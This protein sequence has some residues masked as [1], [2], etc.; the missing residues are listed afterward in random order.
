MRTQC[1]YHPTVPAHFG[2]HKCGAAFCPGCISRREHDYYGKKK[3]SFFCPKC[4]IE[5]D[6]LGMGNIIPPF[7]KRLPAFFL[8]PFRP[9]PIIFILVVAGLSLFFANS[10]FVGIILSVIMLK[11]SYA[12]LLHTAQGKLSPPPMTVS[13]LTDELEVVF[14]QIGIIIVVFFAAGWVFS[15]FGGAAG[16]VFTM[17]AV[18]CLPAMVMSL[19]ATNSLLHAINPLVFVAI[20]FRIGGNYFLMYLFL[21]LLWGAPNVLTGQVASLLPIPVTVF[22]FYAAKNYYMLM[23]YNLMGYTLLQYHDEI[24]YEVEYDEQ[25]DSEPSATVNPYVALLSEVDILIKE[26]KYDQA[27]AVIRD[28]TG[29]EINDLLMAEKYYKLLKF[30]KAHKEQ[31]KHG[32]VYLDLLAEE[33]SKDKAAAI[34]LDCLATDKDF[35]PGPDTLFKMGKWLAWGKEPKLALNLLV[36]FTREYPD[37]PLMPDVYFFLAKFLHTRMNNE[38]KA[39]QVLDLVMSKYSGHPVAVSAEKYIQQMV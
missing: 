39:R 14:K 3:V 20:I 11:Y 8:Y 27:I 23:V 19:G 29:G 21:L 5:A 33:K 30:T 22:V 25:V 10:F 12:V 17:L 24:G 32:R 38:G 9:Q 31:L 6:N 28:D 4:N 15:S 16:V 26:G 2:C 34:Y 37:H 7:W 36:K 13:L 35:T 18:L 1:S